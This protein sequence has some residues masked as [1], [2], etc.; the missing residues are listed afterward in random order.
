MMERMNK[1][2]G[3]LK[4]LRFVTALAA[5]TVA[6]SSVGQ[7]LQVVTPESAGF[8]S[9]GLGAVS[10]NLQQHIDDS[11]RFHQLVTR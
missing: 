4:I 2:T 1:H 10:A 11:S 8:S 7:S 9:A 6:V 5:S 3:P